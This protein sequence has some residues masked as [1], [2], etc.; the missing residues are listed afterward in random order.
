MYLYQIYLT[1]TSTET[2]ILFINNLNPRFEYKIDEYKIL[3]D[4]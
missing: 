4:F 2:F 3:V 1:K